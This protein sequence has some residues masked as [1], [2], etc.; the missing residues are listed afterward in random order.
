MI[1]K[2]L[3]RKI[4]FFIILLGGTCLLAAKVITMLLTGQVVDEYDQKLGLSLGL[5]VSVMFVLV[6][7]TYAGTVYT[8]LRQRFGQNNLAFTA[9]ERGIHNTFVMVNILA[10]MLAAPVTFIPWSAVTYI[11][12]DKDSLYIRVKTKEVQASLI[13]RLI[14]S[15]MGY[16]FC[17][18]FTGGNLTQ[19][20]KDKIRAYCEKQS[21]YL[22]TWC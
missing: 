9:D 3:N 19:Q 1:Q 13:G 6:C 10:F 20:E 2:K 16:Q 18:G 22:K 7:S 11:D 8:L 4:W 17:A 5:M 14:L 12:N 15:V 21:P